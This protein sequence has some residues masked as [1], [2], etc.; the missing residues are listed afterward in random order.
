MPKNKPKAIKK[1]T[2]LTPDPCNAN[3]GTERGAFQLEGSLQKY[4]AG[5]SILTDK[6]G[7]VIAGN[8]TLEQAADLGLDIEVIKTTGDKLVIVQ[9]E[10]LDLADGTKARELAYADNRIAENDLDWSVEQIIAD[11]DA[12]VDL[13]Q[14]WRPEELESV[15]K[16]GDAIIE[17]ELKKHS[18]KPPPK[19]AWC[20]IGIPVVQYG[21][22]SDRIEELSQIDCVEC[23]TVLNDG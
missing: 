13:G 7:V 21:K 17:T 18:T 23:E 22:I 19:M 12:G 10:D 16:D 20:L 2:D 14:F 6:N 4:G 15:I 1:I 11:M 5:R 3:K 8:K 9:R